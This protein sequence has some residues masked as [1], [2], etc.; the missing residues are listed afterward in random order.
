MIRLAWLLALCRAALVDHPCSR[1]RRAGRDPCACQLAC[2]GNC[3]N[4]QD[5]CEKLAWCVGID[6]NA[7]GRIATLKANGP[8]WGLETRI[9]AS[10]NFIVG[11]Q[12]CGTTLAFDA[13]ASGRK[14]MHFF[15][16]HHFVTACRVHHYRP[17][18]LDATPDYFGD[19]IAAMHIASLFPRAKILVLTREPITRAHAAWDQNRRAGAEDRTF[20]QAVVD[21]LPMAQQCERIASVLAR[22]QSFLEY[23]TKCLL[24][25]GRPLNCWTSKAYS[26]KPHCKRYLIK[27]FYGHHLALW[28]S[29]F[30]LI[31]H[32]RAE[33]LFRGHAPTFNN[34]TAFFNVNHRPLPKQSCWHDCGKP[35]RHMVISPQ[36]Q[37]DLDALYAASNQRLDDLLHSQSVASL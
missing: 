18:G 2:I 24:F 3:G 36:L 30:P 25:D 15:D 14:E 29:L 7:N 32:I 34:L 6:R 21:E 37:S 28:A 16:S 4:V 9:S 19:P 11:E 31:A 1:L 12:K 20:Q 26:V 17:R 13:L 5:Q 35:K 33:T 8:A 27:G 23:S 10:V 22:N